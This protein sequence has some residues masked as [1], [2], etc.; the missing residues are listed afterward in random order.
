MNEMLAEELLPRDS[1]IMPFSVPTQLADTITDIPEEIQ[2]IAT[3]LCTSENKGSSK[4]SHSTAAIK[5]L[6]KDA[7]WKPI[8]RLFRRFFKYEAL[9][10]QTYQTIRQ[11][12]FRNQGKLLCKAIGIPEDLAKQ[13]KTPLAMLMICNSHCITR[14]SRLIP[15]AKNL[16]GEHAKVIL[17]R[18]FSVF[19]ENNFSSRK[20]FF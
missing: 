1:M 18:Y 20:A 8:L 12:P 3:K 15:E 5:F 4:S 16:M 14:H 9:T 17:S 7:F 10:W 13:P 2:T 19:N 11:Q 6:Q